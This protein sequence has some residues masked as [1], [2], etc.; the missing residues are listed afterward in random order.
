MLTQ[1]TKD[2]L[3]T[4]RYAPNF[5]FDSLFCYLKLGFWHKSWRLYGFPVFQ[6][7]KKATIRIGEKLVAM[8]TSKHNSLGVF[9]KVMIKAT[10]AGAEICIG[11]NLGISGAT[12]S[13]G[14]QVTIG[15]NVLIGS[16]AMIVDNDAHPLHYAERDVASRVKMAPVQIDD[17]VFIGARAMVLKGVHIGQ[18][19]I[20]GA[21]AVVTKNVAALT[22][23]A[24]NPA[25]VVGAVENRQNILIQD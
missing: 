15:H 14:L 5:L 25:R 12:I 19:A 2:R 3:R 23:V 16:G 10:H 6:I 24:G 17:D 4:L 8:S 18:G 20:I 11:K 22:I 13:C 21:G 9:Q 7:H 1:E